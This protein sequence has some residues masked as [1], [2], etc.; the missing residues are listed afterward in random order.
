MARKRKSHTAAFKAQV[1][2]A[3]V[4]GDKTVSELASVHG[5][6]PTMI[7]AWK[8]QLVEQAEELFQSGAPR[9]QRGARGLAGPTLRAD[10]SAQDGAGLAQK[11]SCQLRLSEACVG[12]CRGDGAEREPAVRT[13]GSES[14]ELLLRAGDGDGGESGADGVDRPGV[15]GPSVFGSRRM[16]AWL[17][18]EGHAVN[19]KR[20]QRL[21]RLMGLEAVYPK[22]RLSA[23]GAGTRCIRTCCGTWR[24]SG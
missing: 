3:A 5:V 24:S 20:V 21:M 10:R 17:Q 13:A 1:A 14:V 11:K 19:R 8:K 15:H 16:A 7:H 18:G 4:K 22:P 6:H 12:R 2:L 23:A 9:L